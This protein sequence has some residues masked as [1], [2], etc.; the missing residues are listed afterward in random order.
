MSRLISALF[1]I[2]RASAGLH[3]VPPG[4]VITARDGRSFQV[5]D[6]QRVV[7]SSQVPML[8]DREHSSETGGTTRAAGWIT[9]LR[10]D[11]NGGIFGTVE[12]TPDGEKEIRTR[13]YR[14]VSP[15]LV[16][17]SEERDVL[18]IVSVA[19]TNRPALRLQEISVDAYRAKTRETTRLACS[20]GSGLSP[21]QRE[22]LHRHGLTDAQIFAA[23]RDLADRKAAY[24]DGSDDASVRAAFIKRSGTAEQYDRAAAYMAARYRATQ[25]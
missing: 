25:Q 15:V 17:D 21:K 19:L 20:M 11:P 22:R 5:K 7:S 12:L 13:V 8:L 24:L 10:A 6:A 9:S 16:L 23:E 14:Y 18:E 4:R 1:E 2:D 3:I